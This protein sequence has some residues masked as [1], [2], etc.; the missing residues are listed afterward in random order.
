MLACNGGGEEEGW[1]VVR[2]NAIQGI[3]LYEIIQIT[4]EG[5]LL[6]NLLHVQSSLPQNLNRFVSKINI[7][8]SKDL[9][10]VSTAE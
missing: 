9:L 8:L 4:S 2:M 6:S 10:R 5:F 7:N 1:W 3:V